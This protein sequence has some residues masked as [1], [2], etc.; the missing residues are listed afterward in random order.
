MNDVLLSN[1]R[2]AIYRFTLQA[3]SQVKL[4]PYAGSTIRGAFGGVF[5]EIT[6]TTK[7][8]TC[9]DC[10][11]HSSCPY[12]Q[13]YENSDEFSTLKLDRFKTPPK[14]FVFEPPIQPNMQIYN[15]GNSFQFNLILIGRILKYLPYF[16]IAFKEMGQNGIGKG[17]GKFKLSKI[18]GLNP[19]SSNFKLIYSVESDTTINEDVSFNIPEFLMAYSQ[20][21][22]G[23][24]KIK[25]KFITPT[26]IK[27]SGSYGNSLIFK[28]LI[29]TLLTRISNMAYNYCDQHQVLNFRNLVSQANHIQIC[30]ENKQWQDVRRFQVRENLE[31]FLGGYVGEIAYEGEIEP[32]WPWLKLGEIMHIGKNCGFGLGKYQVTAISN[33]D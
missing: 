9:T 23:V 21:G 11:L 7:N 25:V 19:I 28:I 4:P 2:I 15:K 22:E 24:K 29:Q 8:E 12:F 1:F 6:C 31:M 30:H 32:F 5:K 20:A 26:R 16:I 33:V 10:K 3:L 17:R 13:I 14:P 27:S 18:E